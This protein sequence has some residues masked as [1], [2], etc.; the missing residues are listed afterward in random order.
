MIFRRRL[1]VPEV[2]QTSAM[3]CGPAA[4]KALLNGYGINA[5]Y[6]RLREACQTDVDGTS[7][8]TLEET[9]GLLGLDAEQVMT[10]PDHL[11]E[12][13]DNLPCQIVVL[14]PGGGTH[15]VVLWRTHGALVQIMDPATGRRWSTKKAF[16]KEVYRHSQTVPAEAWRDWAGSEE[17]LNI[18]GKRA[19]TCGVDAAACKAMLAKGVADP[20]WRAIAA[21]DAA[22]RMVRALIGSGALHRGGEAK[23]L[24][25]ELLA[26]PDNIPGHYWSTIAAVGNAVEVRLTGAVLV[27]VK[28]KKKEGRNESLSSELRAALDEKPDSP[29]LEL[30]RALSTGEWFAP[31]ILLPAL[32]VAAVGT[33]WETMLLRSMFEIGKQL[34]SSGQRLAALAVVAIFLVALTVLEIP[35]YSMFLR[36]GRKMETRLRLKFGRKIPLLNDRYFQSRLASDM[37]QRVHSAEQ[38]REVPEMGGAFLR[39]FFELLFTVAAIGWLYPESLT[40]SATA[41]LCALI[42]PIAAQ[43]LL[44]EADFKWRNHSGAL[45]RFNLD[46]LLG[47]TAILAHG[48]ERA[49]RREQ[50]GLLTEWAASGFRLQA[51]VATLDGV[52]A[53]AGLSL[54]AWILLARLPEP[55]GGSSAGGILLLVYW[56]LRIPA[57]AQEIA[58]VCWRYPSMRNTMLR[59]VEPLGAPEEPRNSTNWADRESLATGVGIK[60]EKLT[61]MAA[62]H[63]ILA[64]INLDIRPGEH[65]GVVGASGAGKSSMVGLLLGW[66][67]AREGRVLIDGEP[68]NAERLD[69]LRGELVWVD[70]QIQIWNSTLFDNL[71]Y[72]AEATASQRMEQTL[73]KAQLRDVLQRLPSGLQTLLGEGGALVS[74]GEGQRVRLGRGM[75][76]G[77]VRLVILD[78]P[79]RGLVLSK[80]QA[81]VSS[82]REVWKDATLICITHDVIDTMQFDRVLVIDHGEICEDG[83]PKTLHAKQD[84]RYRALCNAA[85]VVRSQMWGSGQWRRLR[86]LEGR[87]HEERING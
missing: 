60:M 2:V 56:A 51:I 34:T 28:G 64:N 33:I 7:I 61:V 42:V 44:R 41:A 19:R 67:K 21:I 82:A 13:A 68:L 8:D 43:G 65:I 12:S 48:A 32:A 46:A 62:G 59:L 22:L 24:L 87:V 49:V 86:V 39:L 74:G 31:L 20:T 40:I 26:K 4:L 35:I 73:E 72:G 17:F 53:L 57:L 78:E 25:N 84:S 11:F 6:G 16:L 55:A 30:W 77:K 54:S 3:D 37:A 15:F 27:K 85:E 58:A 14:L 69:Q 75:N 47:L 1:L 50:Q 29:L 80:R 81:M 10:L 9:A 70:P 5:S 23:R 76:K 36:L 18:L 66:H 71:A 79:A 83:N 38:L 45:S 52:Q 63:T